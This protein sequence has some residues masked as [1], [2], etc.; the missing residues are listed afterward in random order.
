MVRWFGSLLLWLLIVAPWGAS[1]YAHF[2]LAAGELWSAEQPYR[3]LTSAVS[4]THLT[5]PTI[6]SV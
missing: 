5:L 6:Y 2:W 4:Y 1:L 3:Q